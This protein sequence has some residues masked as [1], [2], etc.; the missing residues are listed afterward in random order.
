MVLLLVRSLIL[1]LL[2]TAQG[3]RR[4]R[5]VSSLP[6]KNALGGPTGRTECYP[7]LP[8]CRPSKRQPVTWPRYGRRSGSG[9]RT[10]RHD[11]ACRRNPDRCPRRPSPVRL[12]SVP[13][14][15]GRRSARASRR[16][17]HPSSH[18]RPVG[19]ATARRRPLPLAISGTA[20]QPMT[21]LLAAVPV[22]RPRGRGVKTPPGRTPRGRQPSFCI[23]PH[24]GGARHRTREAVNAALL[25]L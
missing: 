2:P 3:S 23:A 10:W 8:A 6:R 19:R 15:P 18:A 7:L 14:H 22:T 17:A 9:P 1:A 13:P 5:L 24:S 4:K 25:G 12:V 21:A 16:G 20:R 11:P